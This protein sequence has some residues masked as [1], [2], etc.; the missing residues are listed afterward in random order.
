MHMGEEMIDDDVG[1]TCTCESQY[2]HLRD[3]Y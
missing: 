2:L 3:P 1:D